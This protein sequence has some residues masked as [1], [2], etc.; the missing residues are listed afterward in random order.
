MSHPSPVDPSL[1]GQPGVRAVA[2]RPSNALRHASP[3]EAI[4]PEAEDDG[5]D[6]R[7]LLR[8]LRKYKWMLVAL[9]LVCGLIAVVQSLRSTP[10]YRSTTLIQI[11]RTAQRVVSF[12]TDVD[13]EQQVWDDG[14]QFQT[15]IE[16]LNSRAL[17][18]RVIAEM[19]LNRRRSGDST[20]PGREAG[21]GI[22]RAPDSADRAAKA[23]PGFLDRIVSNYRQ[24]N[25]P[26]VGDPQTMD[27]N[28][29]VDAFRASVKIEPV[30]NSRLVNI[31]VT[32]SNPDLAAQIANTLARTFMAMNLERKLESSTYARSFLEDQ[33]KVTKAKLE[34]SE[35]VINEYAKSN[36]ILTLDDQ[37]EVA[38]QNYAGLSASL[39][40]AEEERIKA[41]SVYREVLRNPESASQALDNR[42]VQTYK[43]QRAKL[44]AEYTQNLTLYKPDFP[45]MVQLRSQIDDLTA[46]IKAEL[47]L[48]VGSAK[49]QFEAVRQQEI[50]LRERLAQSRA[51]VQVVQDRSVD[52]NLLKREL[53]TNRQVYDSL[54]Q[55]LKEVAVTGGLTSNNIS[56]VDEASP[57]VFPFSPRPERLGAIGMGIGLLLGLGL[58]FLRENM[59]DSL[60]QPDEIERLYGLPL[61]GLIPLAKK[62]KTGAVATLVHDEPR[63][64]FAEAYRSMRTALQFSTH[65]GAPK[66]LMVTS[67][68]KSEGKTTT[69][70]AL[71]INF[72]QL[73]KKVLVIDADMRK[74]S[75]H[76]TLVLPNDA[77]LANFLAGE[78]TVG[79]FIQPTRIENLSVLTAGPT[80]PDPVEL[81]MGP[82]F[83]QLLDEARELGFEHIVVDSPP[84]LGIADAIVLGNQIA[85]VVF[86]VKAGSTRRSAFKDSMRRLRHSGIQPMG[87]VFT[88][89]NDKHGA[90]YGY[91]A[92]YGYHSDEPATRTTRAREV[93]VHGGAGAPAMDVRPTT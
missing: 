55:R 20:L 63:S 35:R 46:R 75:V 36:Q 12:A 78:P 7:D 30:R 74:P 57:A 73:G 33:I 81:L 76:K 56:I 92:Y 54:L 23:P 68:G 77:G 69:A 59:D 45:K 14:S 26:S 29:A 37:S 2:L 61:L 70:I 62:G 9:T 87:V 88:H 17:A 16:L 21:S 42:A 52:L 6:L 53:E 58:A 27:R 90:E 11:D 31:V 89:V 64:V 48:V 10:Q 83:L 13:A 65:E 25:T 15:Q 51:E 38:S 32:N 84:L 41:E 82:R 79:T 85:H 71:A 44:E 4:A 66:L 80:S 39:A 72:A 18:E 28:S 86:A 3:R 5:L 93:V 91:G 67:C 1:P 22:G 60:K 34:E 49:G 50:Q 43:E 24:L 47:S 8:V 19:G 40:R